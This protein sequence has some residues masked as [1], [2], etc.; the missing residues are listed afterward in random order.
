MNKTTFCNTWATLLPSMIVS[1]LGWEKWIDCFLLLFTS[2]SITQLLTELPRGWS[3]CV[4]YPCICTF[5]INL[6]VRGTF[7]FGLLLK[8]EEKSMYVPVWSLFL[9]YI[10]DLLVFALYSPFTPDVPARIYPVDWSI[11]WLLSLQ[12]CRQSLRVIFLLLSWRWAVRAGQRVEEVIQEE[13]GQ[14]ALSCFCSILLLH[15]SLYPAYTIQLH[16]VWQLSPPTTI[17]GGE[18]RFPNKRPFPDSVLFGLFICRICSFEE[19]SS[20]VTHCTLSPKES[21]LCL[22]LRK[23]RSWYQRSLFQYLRYTLVFGGDYL[24][25]FL[26]R[27]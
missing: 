27:I 16:F 3:V 2:F 1:W 15:G 24:P 25:I 26:T 9:N 11:F 23:W 17:K 22:C 19:D 20:H 4:L 12:K 5:N 21:P 10:Q 18:Y 13:Q 8:G 14:M 6:V 7:K